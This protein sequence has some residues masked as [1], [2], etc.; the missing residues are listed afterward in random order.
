MAAERLAQ[1]RAMLAEEPGDPFLRYAIALERKRAGDMEGAAED[2]AQLVREDPKYIACYYQLGLVL[3]DLGR[4][5]EAIGVCDVGSMQC[6]V[7]G[8]RKARTELLQL[9]NALSGDEDA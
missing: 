9:K 2:L 8:D 7:T 5:A 4:T 6:I 1:L 3:A